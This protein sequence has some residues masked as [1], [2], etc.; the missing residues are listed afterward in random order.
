MAGEKAIHALLKTNSYN[1]L[2][3]A[4]AMAR[5]APPKE[6]NTELY[7]NQITKATGLDRNTPMNTLSD[8]QREQFVKAIRKHEGWIVGKEI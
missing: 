1:N 6:N 4:E 3:I 5:Y 8:A 2:S 7:I